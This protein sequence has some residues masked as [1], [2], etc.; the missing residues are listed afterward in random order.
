MCLEVTDKGSPQQLNACQM[1]VRTRLDIYLETKDLLQS[2]APAI[3]SQG[4]L[5]TLSPPP[6]YC[7]VL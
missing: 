7:L 5:P 1:I 4:K 2:E 6:V 3:T